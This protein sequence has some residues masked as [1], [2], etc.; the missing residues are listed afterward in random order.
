MQ[1]PFNEE[2]LMLRDMIREFTA[3]EI[4]P[5]DK[6]MDDSGFDYELHQ[7]MADT[8][9]F[10]IPIPREYGGAGCDFV[11][12]TMAI[13][14][15][16][17]GSA[18]M[19][20]NL[21]S[22]WLGYDLIMAF[23]SEAQK[24]RLLPLAAEGKRIAFAL[25]ESCG[26]SDAAAIRTV[27]A[28]AEGGWIINGSKAWI[29]NMDADFVVIIARTDPKAG[30]RGMSAFIV[31]KETEGLHIGEHEDKAGMRGSITGEMSFD[32]MFL[33]HEAVLGE[34]GQGFK[35]AMMALDNARVSI[36]AVSVGLAEH[37]MEVARDYANERVAFKQPIANFQGIQFKFAQMASK[38]RAMELMLYDAAHM[39]DLGMNQSQEAAMTKLLCTTWTT[40][41]CLEA[42]QVLGGNGCSKEFHV[43]RFVRDAK[44]NEIAE[45]TSEI[46][47]MIIGRSYLASKQ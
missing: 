22:I 26:G 21:D 33:P 30:T 44:M 47:Q 17:K 6:W 12:A 42:Q 46:Q 10:T 8:G 11:T 25:T 13:H 35:Y 23:G 1:F 2:Q 24:Q 39:K 41:I 36:A 3:N 31:P 34:L 40:Q 38:A 16:A 9:I 18:S 14:E 37:A 7:K 28:P 4:A 29:T 20:L 32:N 15:V 27:A 43:E 45:G 5:R 19:A